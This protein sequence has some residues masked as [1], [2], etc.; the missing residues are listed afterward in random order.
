MEGQYSVC[1]FFTDGSYEYFVRFVD[2]KTAT[3]K[4]TACATSVGAIIGTTVR[5]IL[6]DGGDMTNMEWVRGKGIT[7]P[8][9]LLGKLK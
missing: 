8:P 7:F 3:E 2:G 4:F 5:I 1:Q 6:T 9:A